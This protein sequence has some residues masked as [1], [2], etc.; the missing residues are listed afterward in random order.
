MSV[1]KMVIERLHMVLTKILEYH[2]HN[3]MGNRPCHTEMVGTFIII[4]EQVLQSYAGLI[5]CVLDEIYCRFS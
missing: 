5:F 4:I 2:V 3:H 1:L